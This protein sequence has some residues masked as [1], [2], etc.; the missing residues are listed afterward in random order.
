MAGPCA[1]ENK[2]LLI[3]IAKEVKDGG[4]EL[5]P[6]RR[7]QAADLALCLPG[8]G[9]G[10]AQVPCRGPRAH[11]PA[12][13]DRGDGPPGHRAD[14]QIRRRAPDRRPE[15]A[16]LPAAQGSGAVQEAGAPEARHLGHDQGMAHVRR[17]H[18]VRRQPRRDPLRAR[19]PHLRDR[20]PEHARPLRRAR[21]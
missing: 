17:V 15:H 7:I 6:R 18:H 9:R 13:R 11:R 16:E 1:V 20:D 14:R 3:E 12:H 19:H 8:A 10:R 4:R 2:T 21:C 5:P